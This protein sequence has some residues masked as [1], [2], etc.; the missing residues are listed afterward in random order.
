MNNLSQ[1]DN[2]ISGSRNEGLEGFDGLL[3]E[4]GLP[5]G[6]LELEAADITGGLQKELGDDGNQPD[7]ILGR[8]AV[9]IATSMGA[10]FAAKTGMA[11]IGVAAALSPLATAAT[12]ISFSLITN[13]LATIA[14]NGIFG[15]PEQ[16]KDNI[17]S[18]ISEVGG[19]A[20]ATVDGMLTAMAEG[21]GSDTPDSV[22]PVGA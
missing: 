14:E 20:Q 17:R 22:I 4:Q 8:T 10:F 9:R 7:H 21:G 6:P 5:D 3:E 18:R 15:K 1:V 16:I 2:D 19:G 11:A 12:T 13:K